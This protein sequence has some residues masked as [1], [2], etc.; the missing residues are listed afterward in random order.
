MKVDRRTFLG[1]AATGP[2]IF[3]L[4][5][6]F[7]QVQVQEPPPWWKGALKR[8]K[9]TGRP[10]LVFVAPASADRITE[11]GWAIRD[12]LE[13]GDSRAQEIFCSAVVICLRPDVARV[14]L[15]GDA[16]PNV[17]LVLDS[18]GKVVERA[19]SCGVGLENPKSFEERFSLL[20]HG[21][22]DARLAESADKV[23]ASLTDAEKRALA[24]LAAETVEARD[25][26]AREL[27][28]NSE[29]LM[30]LIVYERRHS[31][32]QQRAAVLQRLVDSRFEAAD[33]TAPGPRLPFGARYEAGHGCGAELEE[34]V[35]TQC[36]MARLEG[37]GQRFLKFLDK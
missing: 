31:K 34:G 21:E 19:E 11:L 12:L 1:F 16:A 6:L 28:K 29:A 20:L 32:D 24:D 7:G 5:E 13:S 17:I 25:R 26:A 15:P 30:P 36:G 22:G 37:K 35:P 3:G 14:C 18:S 2:L 33:E 8:M 9:E 23:R 27:A 10:G 4:N